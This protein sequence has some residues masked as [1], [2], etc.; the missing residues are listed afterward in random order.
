[1]AEV[2]WSEPA[3]SDLDT[4][5]AYMALDNPEA[6]KVLVQNVFRYVGQ[7]ADHPQSGFK[8]Q[9]LKRWR[10]RQIVGPPC[11]ISYRE[12]GSRVLI[13]PVIRSERLLRSSILTSRSKLPKK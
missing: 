5:A 1:M 2:I 8:L 12:E 10:Y 7:L 4:I 3:R 11:R 6:A 13:L 9:E